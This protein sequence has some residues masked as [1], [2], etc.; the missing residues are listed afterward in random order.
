MKADLRT[1]FSIAAVL[2]ICA[3]AGAVTQSRTY[4]GPKLTASH[5]RS[6][7]I[8]PAEGKLMKVGM[9]GGESM[10][11][12][13]EDWSDTLENLVENQLK[14]AEV[15]VLP[16]TDPLDSGASDD[17]VRQVLLNVEQK[18][19]STSTQIDRKPKDV[20][21]SRYTLGDGVSLLP[22]ASKSDVLVFVEGQGNVVTGGRKAMG[23]VIGAP[24]MAVSTASLIVTL[25]DA[26]SGD[27][28]AV[29]KLMTSSDFEKNS[30][31][32]FG[33]A[34]DKQLKKLGI[35]VNVQAVKQKAP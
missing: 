28:M 26:K 15:K 35:G 33:P 14:G 11:R 30:G 18:Y 34:L 10:A 9:K 31:K 22:C 5:I 21:K 12:E 29:V 23:L 3:E 25:V 19:Q 8:M 2:L 7:C 1:L 6:A 16:A 32:A 24:G 4:E 27:V 20:R 13:S 17:E